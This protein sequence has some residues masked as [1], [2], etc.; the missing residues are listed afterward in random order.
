[1]TDPN[2]KA[3][4]DAAERAALMYAPELRAQLSLDR[5]RY[6]PSFRVEAEQN[7]S[8]TREFRTRYL[9]P[10]AVPEEARV[11]HAETWA[12]AAEEIRARAVGL[13]PGVGSLGF[14]LA[15]G[16]ESYRARNTHRQDPK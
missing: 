2:G 14:R 4:R 6:G 11:L 9:V 1:M 12:E 15:A 7:V 3:A 13:R 10:V 5:P 16:A 8:G